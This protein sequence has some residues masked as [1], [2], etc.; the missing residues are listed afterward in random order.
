MHRGRG[1]RIALFHPGKSARIEAGLVGELHPALLEGAWGAFEL[2]V[3]ILALAARD[4]VPYEDVITFPAVFRTRIAVTVG[5]EV[6][7][8]CARG[9]RP[10]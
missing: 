4:P 3:E 7:V 5:E 6:E 8:R 9:R 10:T 2:D 1:P